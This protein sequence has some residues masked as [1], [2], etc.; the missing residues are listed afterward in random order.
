MSPKRKSAGKKAAATGKRRTAGRKAAATRKHRAAGV[1]AAA[2][3]K[4]K[5][6]ARKA[7][8]PRVQKKPPAAT[9]QPAAPDP[10]RK[11]RR[12]RSHR[13][14]QHQSPRLPKCNQFLK[15]LP[16]L[17]RASLSSTFRATILYSSYFR[18]PHVEVLVRLGEA[19]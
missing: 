6:A 2:T 19:L 7:V 9:P 14:R 12:R 18:S 10:P 17:G 15:P 4:R 13:Q 1:K 8:A 11:R 3:R 16:T 5:V